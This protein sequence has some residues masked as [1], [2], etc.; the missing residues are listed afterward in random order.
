ML[1]QAARLRK[2]KDFRDVFGKG[3]GVRDNRLFLKA[4][5]LKNE[6]TRFGIVVSKQ[7]AVKAAD[8]NR[9]KRL[10]RESVRNCMP[11][12]K[13]GYDIVLVTLPGFIGTT[14]A[15]VNPQVV[16]VIK[17]SSLFKP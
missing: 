14:L 13:K 6:S 2:T 4:R 12:V 16:N 7:V 1:P 17:K 5:A 9:I 15:D 8:R 3:R 10:L 11:D